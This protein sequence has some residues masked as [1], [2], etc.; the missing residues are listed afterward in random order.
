M[1]LSDSV[2]ST[3]SCTLG[4][5]AFILDPDLIKMHPAVSKMKHTT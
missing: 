2:T 5:A 3:L 4:M 1:N